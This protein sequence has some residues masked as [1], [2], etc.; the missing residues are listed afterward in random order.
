MHGLGF[1]SNK[2][3]GRLELII[4]FGQ[5]V[6]L[7]DFNYL[8]QPK[9][10]L[11]VSLDSHLTHKIQVGAS[12]NFF[13]RKLSEFLVLE[14]DRNSVVNIWPLRSNV[15]LLAVFSVSLEEGGSFSEVVEGKVALECSLTL[16]PSQTEGFS[17]LSSL[18]DL[19]GSKWFQVFCQHFN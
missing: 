18:D 19:S 4:D 14:G 2:E 9:I 11:N 10:I 1:V 7:S 12:V 3:W 17:S 16:A 13:L 6:H 15:Y 8:L 5:R